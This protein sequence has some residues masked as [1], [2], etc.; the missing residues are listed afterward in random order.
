MFQNNCPI[1][2][3]IIRNR[4]DTIPISDGFVHTNCLHRAAIFQFDTSY[5]FN[6]DTIRRYTS[7][8]LSLLSAFKSTFSVE[9][10]LQVDDLR[11]TFILNRELFK[12]AELFSFE[13]IQDIRPFN[14]GSQYINM[15]YRM[16]IRL[17]FTQSHASMRSISLISSPLKTNSQRY[18]HVYQTTQNL[19][20]LIKYI[21][22]YNNYLAQ[23]SHNYSDSQNSLQNNSI[24]IDTTSSAEISISIEPDSNPMSVSPSSH[25]NDL[26]KSFSSINR[27]HKGDNILAFPS[28]YVVIDVETSGL[29]PDTDEIIEFAAA[30]VLN[31]QVIDTLTSL[32][33]PKNPIS[34]KITNITHIT[35][36]MLASAPSIGEFFPY[37]SN[38]IGDSV[39]VGHNVNFDIDFLYDVYLMWS[40]CWLNNNYIDTLRLSRKLFPNLRHRRLKDMIDHFD[41]TADSSLHRALQDVICTQKLFEKLHDEILH[42]YGTDSV[43]YSIFDQT[44]KYI[45]RYNARDIVADPSKADPSHPFYK[46]KVCFT[47]ELSHY[48][49]Q[50]AMQ[51]VADIGGVCLNNVTMH[52]SYLVVGDYSDYPTL[53]QYGNTKTYKLRKAEEYQQKGCKIEIIPESEFNSLVHSV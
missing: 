53:S 30:K 17:A 36:E 3:N 45:P 46:K 7:E 12:F 37:I 47:G 13:L 16:D 27:K 32:I 22:D 21:T 39:L 26:H 10:Y 18:F 48:S 49:R 24:V 4:N 50:E 6:C 51:K 19:L 31:G 43:D 38:F 25:A 8:R 2:G 41:I 14:A 11:K 44:P 33:H 15:C 40:G 5:T 29:N 42:R 28:K 20:S 34:P 35:N 23:T 52:T 1:C 9:K